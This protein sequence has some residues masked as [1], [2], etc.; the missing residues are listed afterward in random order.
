MANTD[1]SVIIKVDLNLDDFE[2]TEKKSDSLATK[3]SKNFSKAGTAVAN[4]IKAAFD[5]TLKA[6]AT[7][8]TAISA[9]SALGIKYNIEMENYLADFTVMLGDATKAAEHVEDLKVMAAETPFEM[10]DL[11]QADKILLAFGSDAEIVQDQLKMLGDISLG[12]A[13]KLSTISTAFGRIQSNGRA[14]MEELNMMIDAGFNPLNIIAAQTGE[15]MAE[16]RDRVS[17]GAVSFEEISEAMRIATSEGGQFYKGM[18][19]ASK[20]ASGQISTLQD[21]VNALLGDLTEGLFNGLKDELLP[22]VSQAVEDIHTAFNEGGAGAAID[23][24][25]NILTEFI[26]E[27]A[28]K[29]PGAISSLL[30]TLLPKLKQAGKTIILSV[31]EAMLGE[32]I[33]NKLSGVFDAVDEAFADMVDVIADKS[34]DISNAIEGIINIVLEIAEVALPLFIDGVS[35]LIDNL[36]VLKPILLGVAAGFVAIKAVSAVQAVITGISGAFSAL[37]AVLMANPVVAT[38]GL[39]AGAFVTLYSVL[40]DDGDYIKDTAAKF[41]ELSTAEQEAVD[42]TKEY[43]DAWEEV[44]TTSNERADAAEAEYGYYQRL[45]DELKTIVDENGEIKNGYEERA[46]V[47]TT[48]LSDALGIEIDIVNDQ[49]SGYQDLQAEIDKV[50]EKKLAEAQLDAYR[51]QYNEAL[52]K[53]NQLRK[54]YVNIAE[55]VRKKE[56]KIDEL[57]QDLAKHTYQVNNSI[58]D[59]SWFLEKW[60][61][62]ANDAIAI[63]EELNTEL[64]ELQGTLG[65]AE[66]AYQ[67]NKATLELYGDALAALESG[68]MEDFNDAILMLGDSM[69]TAQT[70]SEES[71][72]SQLETQKDILEQM[73]QSMR[74]G[75]LAITQAEIDEQKRRVE[76]AEEEY[77]KAANVAYDGAQDAMNSYTQ[78]IEDGEGPASEAMSDAMRAVKKKANVDL[79]S[80]G[81]SAIATFVDGLKSKSGLLAT[82]V[83]NIFANAGISTSSTSSTPNYNFESGAPGSESVSVLSYT[84]VE[85]PALAKGAVIPPNAPYM[86][87]VGDQRNGTNIEAPL[88]TIKQAVSETLAENGGSGSRQIVIPVYISGRQVYEAVLEENDMNTIA[89]G[90]NAFA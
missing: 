61:F 41:M 58:E 56:Q 63:Q 54:D 34:D 52:E 69:L 20:T 28:G 47:I 86:A 13:D 73:E 51:G 72:K 57:Q 39:L 12:N 11:A 77:E 44:K 6:I 17:A 68:E 49:I 84:P 9:V 66:T 71:L 64:V 38:I 55:A 21:N 25:A 60:G 33:A 35:W 15:T 16:V 46:K 2:K 87:I 62:T 7:T 45:S 43:V 59:T 78:G 89:T 80:Q 37:S 14:S 1:G 31:V 22:R 70:A 48:T 19:V 53:Q 67:E 26:G 90:K 79:T 10:T 76:L 74:D 5:V 4:G 75:S 3:L 85:I 24:A 50:I 29:A 8:Y 36:D 18:E 42:R 82:T 88:E 32:D 27:I 81:K 30:K 40:S 23:T 83:K 65:D